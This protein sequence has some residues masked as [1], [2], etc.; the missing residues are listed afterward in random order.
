MLDG[1]SAVKSA[2]KAYELSKETIY[3]RIFAHAL[4]MDNKKTEAKSILKPLIQ[5]DPKLKIYYYTHIRKTHKLLAE[6]QYKDPRN[7]ELAEDLM[8][9]YIDHQDIDNAIQTANRH[10]EFRGSSMIVRELL[11]KIA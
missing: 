10:I 1:Q 5:K 8:Q 3:C 2:R 9:Y 11:S 6:L 4:V 7:C